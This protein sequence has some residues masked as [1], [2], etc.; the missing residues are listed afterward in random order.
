MTSNRKSKKHIIIK[1][2]QNS[3][4]EENLKASREKSGAL[5]MEV[6]SNKNDPW[7]IRNNKSQNI[8]GQ[9]LEVSKI[10]QLLTE[11]STQRKYPSEWKSK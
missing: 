8:M 2:F 3:I 6:K 5:I 9:Q 7:L 4:K 10:T 1:L 11:P